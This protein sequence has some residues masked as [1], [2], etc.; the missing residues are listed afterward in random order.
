MTLKALFYATCSAFSSLHA[1]VIQHG[2]SLE[3]HLALA[4]DVAF[5]GLTE[6]RANRRNGT[7]STGTGF[8]FQ[9]G[10]VLT[11]A[12]VVDGFSADQITIHRGGKSHRAMFISLAPGWSGNP[13]TGLNQGADLAL[14][15]LKNPT[16]TRKTSLF[17]GS[18][19]L[20]SEGVFLGQGFSGTGILGANGSTMRLAGTNTIDREFSSLGGGFLVTDFDDGS[21]RRNALQASTVARSFYDDGFSNPTLSATVLEQAPAISEAMPTS[22]E[23]TT[24]P[25]DSGGPLLVQSSSDGSWQLAGITSWGT[26]P[27]LPSG[28]SRNDS[29]YGDLTFFTD[30]RPHHDWIVNTIPEPK[31][32]LQLILA[33]AFLRFRH[34]S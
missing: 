2:G 7:G 19:L 29:R 25:G 6:I 18:S 9:P 14:L 1:V 34:R 24:A 10:W 4:N 11:A 12:H 28:F 16:T 22:L 3:D 23:A 8:E 26:N 33:I 20:G 27:T 13:T 15:R 30:L 21:E 31:I 32:G 17:S 5:N